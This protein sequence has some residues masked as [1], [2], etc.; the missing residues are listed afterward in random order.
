MVPKDSQDEV[1]T[2]TNFGFWDQRLALEWTYDNIDSFG[3]NKTNI[4]VGGLSAGAYSTFHQLAHDIGPNCKRQIIRRVL[5]FSNGCGVQPKPISEAVQQTDIF[6]STLGIPRTWSVSERMEAL[7]GKTSD[8]LINAVGRMDQRF[9]RPVLDDAFIS[10]D[11]FASIYNG[12]FGRRMKNLG[13]QI[14]IGDLTQEF[15]SYKKTYPPNSYQSLVERLSW[16]YPRDI[17]L[18][19][20]S[21]FE[22]TNSSPQKSGEDW[23][24]IFGY[25]YADLQIHSTMR[26]FIH[27]IAQTLP[28]SNIY[29][30][31]IDWR[32]RSVDKRLPRNL[33][34]THA[35]DMS[36]W[37]F[38]NGDTLTSEEKERV[39]D[40]LQP[41]SA[42]IKGDKVDWGTETVKQVRYLTADGKIEI[43]DDEWWSTKLA[44][45]D[46]TREATVS[47]RAPRESK[48]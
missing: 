22:P 8:E 48:L 3:G 12:N 20:C 26:G 5:Q 43:K 46:L 2:E 17:V 39:T 28:V 15:H 45:W 16:D 24:K 7:R 19:V 14:M 21:Q 40:W 23:I 37:F 34:A 41:L 13:I 31:R 36:I 10:K 35:T 47:S 11:L 9:F 38:G 30:Y 33:G 6:L 18:A 44:L 1:S 29:R 42:F 25:L 4:T 32:T 27:S